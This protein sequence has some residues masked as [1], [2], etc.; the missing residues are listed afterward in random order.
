MCVHSI[1][2]PG[3]RNFYNYTVTTEGLEK[4]TKGGVNESQSKFLE[5][6]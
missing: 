1:L 2:S 5:G 4:A 6:T 3:S